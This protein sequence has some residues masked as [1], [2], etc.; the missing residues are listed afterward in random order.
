MAW[1]FPAAMIALVAAAGPVVVHLLRRHQ[2]RRIVLPT[3][4]FVVA[5]EQS[6]PR[7][8]RVSDPALMIVRTAV[9]VLAVLALARPL[10]LT[11]GR[12]TRWS[13]RMAR[14]VIVDSREPSAA[15][16]D[17]AIAAETSS[18][19]PSAVVKAAD[20]RTAI[21]RGAKWLSAAPPVR[22]EIVV[23]SDFRRGS[24]DADALAQVPDAI[25]VRLVR[26]NPDRVQLQ[27]ANVRLLDRKQI[28]E[29]DVRLEGSATKVSY[30]RGPLI[31]DG[32]RL[33]AAADAQ[34]ESLTQVVQSA[35][36]LA[37]SSEQPLI[38]RF[39]KP[40]TAAFSS[41]T[42]NNRG[43]T[44]GAG[45][46]LLDEIEPFDVPVSA[47]AKDGA[48][49]VEVGVDP[50][51]LAAA[52][53]LKSALD[54]RPDPASLETFETEA[55]PDTTLRSWSRAPGPADPH[56]WRQTDESDGR[57]FWGLALLLLAIEGLMRR[58]R[59]KPVREVIVDAA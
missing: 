2:A 42:S 19:D 59:S 35:G 8:K 26:T 40:A 44:L 13:E 55:I 46:R 41:R 36:A 7:L 52:R 4:R 45:V 17:E 14:V 28:L 21:T 48:L 34:I 53:V 29:G 6:A 18:A 11:D 3:V 5:A 1:L 57:W 49:V 54:A 24:L 43:W 10:F 31:L 30:S 58:S 22:R 9:I 27:H 32:L 25:G 56:Q 33:E 50:E 20:L 51:S 37:P 16:S 38:I 23:I 15:V 47:D 39:S 12:L